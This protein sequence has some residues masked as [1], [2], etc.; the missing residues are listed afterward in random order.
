MTIKCYRKAR[1]DRFHHEGQRPEGGREGQ[2]AA[3]E[4]SPTSLESALRLR[5]ARQLNATIRPAVT[6][7]TMKGKG[8][9][10]ALKDSQQPLRVARPASSLH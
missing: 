5:T 2:S 3:T 4:S 7:F 8:Q 9:K 10:E 1:C 6:D